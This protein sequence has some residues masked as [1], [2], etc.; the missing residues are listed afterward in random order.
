[1]KT[2]SEL[3]VE[4]TRIR[5]LDPDR[6][7]M[8]TMIL[9]GASK[10]AK[11][12]REEVSSLDLLT[13]VRSLISSTSGAIELIHSK[14]T[15]ASEYEKQLV[16]YKEFLGPQLSEEE[17]KNRLE[18]FL[19]FLVPEERTRKNIKTISAAFTLS[20]ETTDD[21]DRIDPKMIG[22]LLSQMLT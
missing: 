1:M 16:L 17:V 10:L 14:G 2:Y 20:L 18:V 9:D 8:L 3:L 6:Y 15:D 21:K 11:T 12:R 4:K 7:T 13:S 22:R 19:G 5:M